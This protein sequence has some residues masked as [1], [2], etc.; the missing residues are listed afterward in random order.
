MPGLTLLGLNCGCRKIR[1]ASE[2]GW[3]LGT[4]HKEHSPQRSPNKNWAMCHN[5]RR[6]DSFTVVYFT[7]FCS[8]SE[9]GDVPR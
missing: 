1:S 7:C 2:G 8:D 4:L 6:P 5:E 3:V 9:L